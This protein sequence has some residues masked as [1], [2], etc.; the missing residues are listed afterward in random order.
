MTVTRRALL[1]A[2]ATGVAFGARGERQRH[3]VLEHGLG[4]RDHVVDR[5]RKAAFEQR[6]GACDKHQRLRGARA[7]TP[8]DLRGEIACVRTRTRRAHELED[9]V[10]HGLADRQPANQPLRSD[11]FLGT[12]DDLVE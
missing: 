11:Q 5:G 4:H 8:C 2:A 6:A 7:W 9:R 3:A 1:T 12:L 10:D